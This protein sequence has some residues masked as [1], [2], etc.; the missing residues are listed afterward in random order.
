[1][2]LLYSLAWLLALPFA[3]FHLLWRARRQPAYLRHWGER[4]GRAPRSRS[5][6]VIWIHAVSVGETRAAAPL[7]AALK[8]SHPDHAIMLTHATPTGRATG[9]ELFG[10]T[11]RRAYLPYDLPPLVWLFLQRVRPVMGIILETELWPNLVAACAHE[12]IPLFLVNAR[13]SEKSALGYGRFRPLVQSTLASLAGIAAQTP[14][15]ARRLEELGAERVQVT[16]NL[17]FD[18]PAPDDTEAR[19]AELRALFAGRFVLLAA[20]TREGEEF[21]VLDALAGLP[22]PDLLLVLVPRHP[23][24]FNSVARLVEARGLAYARRSDR[25]VPGPETRVF[26]GDSMGEMAA[27]YSAADLAY[28]GGSLLPLGGQN[29]IEAAAAGCPALIGPHTWNFAEAAE[30]AIACGAAARVADGD[31]LA[32]RV[33]QLYRDPGARAAMAKAGLAFA[34]ANRGATDKVMAL[35]ATRWNEWVK[36]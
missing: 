35:L 7:V 36:A 21:L 25:G 30:Q 4:L 20:S 22:L 29:L 1:M 13:L 9:H 26:L 28:V 32:M 17:K 12:D 10:N 14:D 5:R 11:V 16:G 19:A 2:R 6:P 15:D 3:F 8:Q 33:K 18:V 24:R 27:Y 34:S 31:E 23:H